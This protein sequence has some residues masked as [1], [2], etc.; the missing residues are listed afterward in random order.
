MKVICEVILHFWYILI[1][2]FIVFILYIFMPRIKGYFGEKSTSFFLSFLDK[3]KY[4]VIN[5]VM[6]KIGEKTVQIDHIVVSDYGIFVVETKNYSGSIKGNDFDD[7]W[8]QIFYRNEKKFYNP[9]KQNYGHIKAL[10]RVLGKYGNLKYISIVAFTTKAEL[11]VISNTDVVYTV[12]IDKTIEKYCDE[13][14]SN[15]VKNK[16]YSEIQSLNVNSKKMKK[17]HIREVKKKIYKWNYQIEHDIC[18]KCGGKLIVKSGKYGR[19]KRCSNY[20]KC[21]FTIKLT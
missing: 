17:K 14:I 8:K 9:V 2:F 20:P 10:K 16:I 21:R 15:P 6:L 3:D 4:S 13:C 18:P 1:A 5:N 11:K 12:D 7:N 19:F